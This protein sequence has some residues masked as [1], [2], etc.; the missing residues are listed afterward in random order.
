[1]T[2]FLQLGLLTIAALLA[3][4]ALGAV[5]LLWSKAMLR[6]PWL[7]LFVALVVGSST[8]SCGYAI[9]CTRG[10]T[11]MLPVL[12]LLG[13]L[14]WLLRQPVAA[15]IGVPY[16]RSG[17]Q[18]LPWLLLL[19]AFI[20][21]TRYFLLFDS[22]SEFLRTP[23]QD[24]VFYARLAT[25]LALQGVETNSLE[26][27]YPQFLAPYPYHYLEIWWNA[28]LVH[29]TGLPS[30]FCMF[31]SAFS[32]MITIAATGFAAIFAHFQL[33]RSFLD[34]YRRSMAI[35]AAYFASAKWSAII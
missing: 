33:R 3:S 30:V 20:F 15:T 9:Y 14:L 28:L 5:L 11:I 24:Y 12:L 1:M 22:E 19:A 25:P 4:Y 21:L 29:V 32:V 35:F 7:A 13:M 27:L 6:E 8:L 18:L 2:L 23:F 34:R 10:V 26:M 17:G 31:L 16:S